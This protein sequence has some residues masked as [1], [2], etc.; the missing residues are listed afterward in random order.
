[1]S[2]E[3]QRYSTENQSDV[4]AQYAARCGF[5]I[6]RTYADHGKSGLRIEGRPALRQLLTDVE[7]GDEIAEAD[8]AREVGP[9]N[10]FALGECSK[11]DAFALGECR[12]EPA[13]PEKQ[14]Y[15]PR[16]RPRRC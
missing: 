6:V 2:T 1:M 16:I 11:D 13:C 14:L 10:T 9:A 3:H 15:Q 12:V 7:S 8:E 5:D 4:I